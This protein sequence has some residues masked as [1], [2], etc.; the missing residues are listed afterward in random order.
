MSRYVLNIC[1]TIIRSHE[2]TIDTDRDIDEV[3]G[4]IENSIGGINSIWDMQYIK[5]VTVVK[6]VE[7]EDGAWEFEVE[8]VSESE[9]TE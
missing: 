3:C 6:L 1:E 7:D 2:V 8:C 5:G 4:E 9:V